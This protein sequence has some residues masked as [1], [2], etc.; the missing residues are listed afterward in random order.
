MDKNE[1][2]LRDIFRLAWRLGEAEAGKR[3]RDRELDITSSNEEIDTEYG[4]V[5]KG[6]LEG[7]VKVLMVNN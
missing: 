7:K 1:D 3:Y 5:S 4:Y 6:L 2:I